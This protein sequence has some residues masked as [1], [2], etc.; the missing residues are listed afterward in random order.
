M[1][2]ATYIDGH[3]DPFTV[4]TTTVP[5]QAVEVASNAFQK[6]P[7]FITSIGSHEYWKWRLRNALEAALPLM[8]VMHREDVI[9]AI[10]SQ[11]GEVDGIPE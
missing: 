7:Q 8:G 4:S 9:D 3:G 6:E 1:S 11:W 2:K 10:L 5:E